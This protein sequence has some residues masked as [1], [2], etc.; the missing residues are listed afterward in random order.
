MKQNVIDCLKERGLVDAMTSSDLCKRAEKPLTVYIG[1]DPTADSLH[2]G[3]LVGIV[4][5]GWFQRFGHRPVAL[6]GG[7]TG[8]IGDPSGKSQER[9]LLSEAMLQK[10][11]VSIA[12][13]LEQILKYSGARAPLVVNNEEWLSKFSLLD[14]LRDIGRQFR[15]GPMLAK[16]SVRSRMDAEEGMSFTEFSYQL[17]QSYDFYYL[18]EHHEVC[19]QIGGSDQWGN[20]TSGIELIRKLCGKTAF[21]LTWP[22]LTRSDGKK[23]GKTEEGAV[24]L[25]SER[26]SPYHFYQYFIQIPDRDVTKLLRML[27]YMD[28]AEINAIEAAM[29]RPEYLPN[30]AQMRLAEE[31][32]RLVHGEEGLQRA[33]RV[34][35][36]A[37]PGKK[38]LLDA[39]LLKEISLD[40][41]HLFLKREAVLGS[42]FIDVMA[43]SGVVSS[44]GEATRLIRN[45]GAYLNEERVED[46]TLVLEESH[47]I[48]GDCLLIA[49][50][51][52]K[53]VLI[54]LK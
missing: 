33:L 47:F 43:L 37:A 28:L 11:V 4:A 10:N 8:R 26:S 14:F 27:T 7:A 1:F 24:W 49:S 34:T 45:G 23:F 18:L 30:T 22:L 35:Q 41:P 20:I 21:G 54:Q 53:K 5:L 46:P 39:A 42:K 12:K 2:V 36:A 50:G 38:A 29:K 3:N 6:L 17:L 52:K 25:S 44:K 51:K 9:P 15:V 31:A 13:Q 16:E 32:T 40:I 19:L 48:G